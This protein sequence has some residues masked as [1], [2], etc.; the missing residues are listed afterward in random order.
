[1]TGTGQMYNQGMI[2]RPSFGGEYLGHGLRIGGVGAEAVY[3]LSR[4]SN[5]FARLQQL[6][7]ARKQLQHR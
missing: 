7:G 6:D 3:R 5:E 1:M 2:G 4:K